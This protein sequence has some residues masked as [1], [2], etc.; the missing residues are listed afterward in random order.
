MQLGG[1]K[2]VH[3]AVA[4][5]RAARLMLGRGLIAS[6]LTVHAESD[7]APYSPREHPGIAGFDYVS[8]RL[9]AHGTVDARALLARV[10]EGSAAAGP[11]PLAIDLRIQDGAFLPASFLRL[12]GGFFRSSSSFAPHA[13]PPGPRWLSLIGLP[14]SAPAG[15]VISSRLP[16]T[17]S[18]R[19][20]P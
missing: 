19:V 13:P 8:G 7:L 15:S 14:V 10:V 5:C 16:S 12:E 4:D 9:Q 1:D 20:V 6:D 11:S 3:G 17:S 2:E 18:G